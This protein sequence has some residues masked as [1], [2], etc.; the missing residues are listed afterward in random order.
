MEKRKRMET[1]ELGDYSLYLR[2]QKKLPELML[3]QYQRWI[4]QKRRQQSV[5]T[6]SE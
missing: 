6:L 2:L 5:E 1:E 4:Y 3:T